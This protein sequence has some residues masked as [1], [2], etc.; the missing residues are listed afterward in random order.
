MFPDKQLLY[1]NPAADLAVKDLFSR[2]CFFIKQ[3]SKDSQQ[4]ENELHALDSFLG[5]QGSTFLCADRLSHLD[6]EV[7]PKLHHIRVASTNLKQFAIPTHL[8]RVWA[9]LF[10]A[11]NCEIFTQ[12]CPSDQ[13][14]L[15]HWQDR[16]QLGQMTYEAHKKL[17]N[18]PPKYSFDVPVHANL[19]NLGWLIYFSSVHLRVLL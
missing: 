19:V 2:F 16:P 9:Y 7:L 1:N 14:I 17:I 5:S 4:L 8:T 10:S 15:L 18:A 12:T 6:L 11:Y 13:E 3:V